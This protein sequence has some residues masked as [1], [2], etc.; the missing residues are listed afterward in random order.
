MTTA[1]PPNWSS[2][3]LIEFLAALYGADEDAASRLAVELLAEGHD[4]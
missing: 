4:A 3:Q 1:P 2:Q